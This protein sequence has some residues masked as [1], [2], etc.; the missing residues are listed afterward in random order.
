MLLKDHYVGNWA[1]F[2]HLSLFLGN[3]IS[4]LKNIIARSK[5]FYTCFWEP[6]L[7]FERKVGKDWTWW[8]KNNENNNN[9]AIFQ[10]WRDKLINVGLP[11]VANQLQ[12][13]VLP[14]RRWKSNLLISVLRIA[15]KKLGP[16]I[17][18]S[19]FLE[20]NNRKRGIR[21]LNLQDL[22]GL[23]SSPRKEKSQNTSLNLT[24]IIHQSL[25]RSN[26][27]NGRKKM[28]WKA[29][30]ISRRCEKSQ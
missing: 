12:W 9:K 13:S 18:W 17:N 23:E 6:A 25:R 4:L 7:I 14:V 24:T 15:S 28:R 3:I 10:L 20:K 19:I 21:A 30:K 5:W 11:D 2:Y 16:F 27:R 22:W 1:R 8:T 26:N 29:Q